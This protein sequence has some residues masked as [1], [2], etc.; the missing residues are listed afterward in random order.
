MLFPNLGQYSLTVSNNMLEVYVTGAWDINMATDV[1]E[2]MKS[3]VEEFNDQPWAALM[4][5]RR[6]VLST[7]ESQVIVR[8]SILHNIRHGLRRSAYVVDSGNVKR[9]QLARTH[10]EMNSSDPMLALYKREYFTN[11]LDAIKW[12]RAEGFEP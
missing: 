6:W 7:P 3:V 2:E 9:A 1:V 4:D 11:Y 12:L 8:E 5:C 10:P